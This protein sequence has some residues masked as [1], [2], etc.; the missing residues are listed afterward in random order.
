MIK[1]NLF[2]HQGRPVP[3]VAR[4]LK[5]LVDEN[6]KPGDVSPDAA[7]RRPRVFTCAGELDRDFEA[8]QR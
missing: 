7:E 2:Q 6:G 4:Q 3:L 5:Q 8:S 1:A